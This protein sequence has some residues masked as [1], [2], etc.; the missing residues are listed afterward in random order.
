[1]CTWGGRRE[2]GLLLLGFH[3]TWLPCDLS[4]VMQSRKVV[5]LSDSLAVNTLSSF[6]FFKFLFICIIDWVLLF[7]AF[8]L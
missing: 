2:C 7:L 5:I 1:M 4:F 8:T 6:Y 3:A